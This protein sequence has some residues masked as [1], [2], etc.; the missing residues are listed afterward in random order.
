MQLHHL[1]RRKFIMLL[2][3]SAAV[4]PLAARGQQLGRV[5]R[6]GLLLPTTQNPITQAYVNAMVQQLRALGYI[7]GRNLI[8]IV[9]WADG[10][11]DRLPKLASELVAERPDVIAAL[12]TPGVH[13]AQRAT[14]TI[15]IVMVAATD[16]IGS[17]FVTSLARPGGNIT[18]IS[19]MSADLTGKTLEILRELLPS[20]KR[21]AVLMSPN[22][23]HRG[24]YQEAEIAAR[25]IG[26][27]VIPVRVPN[28]LDMNDA[29]AEIAREKC[30]ALFVLA[31]A[32]P[33]SA[34]LEF[35][36]RAKLPAIYQISQ[37]VRAG[38]LISYGADFHAL[39][40]RSAIYIDKILKGTAPGD[41]PIEQPVKFE[42]VINVKTAKA[43][44]LTV[45]PSL[46][47]RADEVIE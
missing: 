19:H 14:K 6:V 16:P 23:V 12:A 44:G 3:G 8:L 25:T 31:D 22:P 17:G 36:E 30:D 5:W 39:F 41:L 46:L 2:G 29:F 9:R 26:V 47:S 32:R 18:G 33:V 35:A 10:H 38:G 45:P 11:F 7:E 4:W 42:L 24:Q 20:A 43:I 34:I 1:R 40:G 27:V 37:Q 15:P 13:A 21:I 28:P